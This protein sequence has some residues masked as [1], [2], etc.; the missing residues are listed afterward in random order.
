MGTVAVWPSGFSRASQQ[1]QPTV[2]RPGKNSTQPPTNTPERSARQESKADSTSMTTEGQP[3]PVRITQV[4]PPDA[5]Y[6][7]YVYSTVAMATFTIALALIGFFGIRTANRTLAQVVSQTRSMQ[8]QLT[9]MNQQLEEMRSAGK[10]TDRLI[11]QATISAAAAKASA[12]ALKNSERSWVLARV[13]D[14]GLRERLELRDSVTRLVCNV[15][16]CGKT[17]ALLESLSVKMDRVEKI[18]SLPEE[19]DYGSPDVWIN[20]LPLAPNG[21]TQRMF[22]LTF[23]DRSSV[24][25]SANF[26]YLYGQVI[27]RDVYG[28]RHE[29]RFCYRFRPRWREA[30]PQ[31]AGFEFGGPP[32]YN[33]AT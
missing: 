27:Y 7:T 5:L 14:T 15:Q 30:D 33:Q 25:Q 17:L 22:Y 6:K 11:E 8:G 9:T 12:D 3:R 26:L 21:F 19:P 28:D 10:Q 20:G 4:P 31:T 2:E 18:D 1:D 24:E 13:D 29:T 16:N 23:L 32:S